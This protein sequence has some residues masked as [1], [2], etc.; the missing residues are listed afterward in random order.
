VCKAQYTQICATQ[1]LH[2]GNKFVWQDPKPISEKSRE[3]DARIRNLLR[4]TLRSRTRLRPP[5]PFGYEGW[6]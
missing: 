2:C 1:P 5:L 4:R 3:P 6:I